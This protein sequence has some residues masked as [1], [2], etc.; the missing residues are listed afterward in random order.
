MKK[1][2]ILLVDDH[3]LMR[4]GLK[5]IIE[6][7]KD[8]EVIGQAGDG[9][10]ALE[11]V[12]QVCPDVILLDINMPK[13]NGIQVL[14]RLKDMDK[15]T[16]V[17]MLTFHEDREYLFETINLGANGYV[18]KDAESDSL[19]KAIRDVAMGESYIHP[20]LASQ[21]V[22]EFN[23]RDDH[24]D[25]EPREG[26]LTKREYEVLTLIAEGQNNKEIASNLFISEKTVKNHVSNIFKKIHVN[27][28]TQAAIYAYKHNIKKI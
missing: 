25:K 3:S 7:E 24:H 23:R 11:K 14:R 21:L 13:L 10:E 2:K 1:I 26:K 17:I 19:I 16:K 4:Q 8:M 28:R 9:E 20:S 18:L 6:L 12:K 22:K 15:T 5:Q 27:D